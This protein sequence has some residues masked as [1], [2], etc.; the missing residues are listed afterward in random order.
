MIRLKKLL[1]ENYA[2]DGGRKFGEKLPTLADV[3]KKKNEQLKE[4]SIASWSDDK[5]TLRWEV[6]IEGEK[7]PLILTG[8]SL[9]IK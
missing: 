2:W 9:P 8:R 4:T 6:Y 5:K 1:K 7:E 3:Q